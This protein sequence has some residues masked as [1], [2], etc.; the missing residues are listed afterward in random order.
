VDTKLT[1]VIAIMS[2]PLSIT[3]Y[4]KERKTNSEFASLAKNFSMSRVAQLKKYQF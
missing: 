3:Q 1:S 4:L 2:Y